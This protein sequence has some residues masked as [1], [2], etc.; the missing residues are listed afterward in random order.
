MI[1]ISDERIQLIHYTKIGKVLNHE[2]TV[3]I[4]NCSIIITGENLLIAYLNQD[5]IILKGKIRKV[6]FMYYD[7]RV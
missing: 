1:T 5:E 6:D 3:N 2:I 7:E 4:K